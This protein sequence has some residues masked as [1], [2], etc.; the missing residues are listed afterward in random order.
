MKF[1]I[2]N[3]TLRKRLWLSFGLFILLLL[4]LAS[5]AVWQMRELALTTYKLHHHPYTVGISIRELFV[6]VNQVRI[7][8]LLNVLNGDPNQ[9]EASKN[10]IQELL[11][12]N[13][14]K[15]ILMRERFL[16]DLK[17]FDLLEAEINHWI[18][19]QNEVFKLL[20]E[21]NREQATQLTLFGNLGAQFE[22][23]QRIVQGIQEFGVKKA[24]SYVQDAQLQIRHT[25]LVMLIVTVTSALLM[26][27][28]A[29]RLYHIVTHPL[30]YALQ[31][32]DN[33]A[34]GD[35]DAPIEIHIQD[36]IGQLLA[37]LTCLQTQLRTRFE[38]DNRIIEDINSVIQIAS[39]GDFSQRIDL[40][41]KSEVFK[42]IAEGVNQVL[43]FNQSAIKDLMRMFSAVTRGD[44]T[45]TITNEY[46][47][48]LAQLKHDANA[49]VSKLMEILTIIRQSSEVVSNAAE[50]IS[51]ANSNLS[52]RA[53]Q[54][55]S[56]L[57]QT[58]ASMQ[59][60]T[61][62]VQQ[63]ADNA[64]QANQ[65]ASTAREHAELGNQVVSSTISAINEISQ[66][67][68]KISEIITVI[69]E[70]A[71]QTN[72]LALNAAVE[73][74][75]A[76]EHGRGFAVVASEVRTLAQR[77]ALAA[78]EIKA[79][80]K[81]STEKMEEG[82]RLVN[83]SGQ[84]L[85]EIVVA[86]K[87]V[88]D[89]IGEIAMASVEQSQGIEQVNKAVVQMDEMVEQNSALVE[90]TASASESMKDQAKRLKQQVAFFKMGEIIIEEETAS[91]NHYA[92]SLRIN[93]LSP[94]RRKPRTNPNYKT[95]EWQDF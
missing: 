8:M 39:K 54:Q 57:E 50:E 72:L 48:E 37:G 59:Q 38:E 23:V 9:V 15:M 14:Q 91:T 46:V 12:I 28:I 4:S 10:K 43:N 47:G 93:Q 20:K 35:L 76:G 25:Y 22:E 71:F 67:G 16:G 73:A 95:E 66:S 45:E 80:I 61:S 74:A 2:T 64:K 85:A 11:E 27:W 19:L 51:Q 60:M 24:G 70:I 77:S 68:K 41:N 7:L 17:D 5:F 32:T 13:R 6:N 75:R 29:W 89:I 55:A 31:I 44:L 86:V 82:T 26:M 42:V 53:T 18:K 78:K 30:N 1:I 87:K 84:T 52:Q 94:N 69:D 62:T 58:A 56:S 21:N 92:P 36:E 40:E 34:K 3:M 81:D 79:L 49:T 63:N 65:L 33:I 88:G 83:Q 90:E